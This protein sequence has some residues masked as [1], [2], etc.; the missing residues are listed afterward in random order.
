MFHLNVRIV[1]CQAFDL[2][3]Y[4][5]YSNQYKHFTCSLAQHIYLVLHVVPWGHVNPMEC[6]S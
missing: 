3:F 2:G 1:F 4:N 5:E 6:V